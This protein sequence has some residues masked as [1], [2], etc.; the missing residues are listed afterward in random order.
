MPSSSVTPAAPAVE[1]NG[2]PLTEI[3]GE[4]GTVITLLGTAHISRA[5][6]DT[7]RSLVESGG[8]DSV[9]VELCPSRHNAIVDPDAIAKMDLFQ[10]IRERK[11]ALVAAHLAL[12]AYQQRMAE[13]LG[14]VPGA[15]MRA[16]IESAQACALPVA[17]IDREIGVTLKRIYHNVSWWR[18]VNLL[19]GVVTSAL[20]HRPVTA[21]EIE[22]LKEG[23]MLEST[24]AQF[25]EQA[26]ELYQPLIEERDRYMSA[27]ITEEVRRQGYRRLLVVIGAG[28]MRGMAHHLREFLGAGHREDPAAVIAELDTLPRPSRWPKLIPWL[29]VA[30]I[31]FGFFLGFTHS[32]ALGWEMVADWVVI[33]GGLAAFGALI[34]AAHPLTVLVAFLAAPLTSLNPMIGAGMVT[35]ACEIYLRRPSVAD[36][37]RLRTDTA[38]VG[39]WWR[40]RVARTLLIFLLSTFG[41]AAG[42]Y[43]AGALIY[44]RL[45]GS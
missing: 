43:F 5:S 29:I 31:L 1:P 23:D 6:A 19:A 26:Q 13:Q 7:A 14:I 33:N 9:A 32:P 45:S 10:V 20:V 34:A 27:R 38:T 21:E 2:E 39:G 8:Y 22:R 15:E 30:L 35:A 4:D 44:Q 40:N 11:A 25:A 3:V 41:S 28:H 17:L 12:G 36:F 18:R 16:A 24:F 42:T 37:T